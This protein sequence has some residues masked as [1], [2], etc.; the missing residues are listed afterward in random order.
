LHVNITLV[1]RIKKTEKT[2]LLEWAKQWGM[3]FNVA[4][5]KV[6]QVGRRN[7]PHTYSLD[8]VDL[9]QTEEERDIGVLVSK[10][11]KPG[12]QCCKAA[13]TA[14]TVLGQITRSFKCRD[15][16]TFVALYQRYVR[17]HLEFSVQVWSP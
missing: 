9:D 14:T 17:P 5:C 13:R 8:G 11:L 4:K 1:L 12:A 15:K 16:K 10:N 7:M 3:R 2:G 6:M